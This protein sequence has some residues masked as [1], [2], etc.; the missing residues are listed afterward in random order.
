MVRTTYNPLVQWA[1]IHTQIRVARHLPAEEAAQCRHYVDRAFQYAERYPHDGRTLFLAAELRGRL[2]RLASGID[3]H[4]NAITNVADRLLDRQD[5]TTSGLSGFFTE[6]Q[7]T[8]AYRS[9]AFSADPALALLRLYELRHLL[10]N[11][12]I[13]ARAQE[14]IARYVEQY[15]LADAFSNPFAL[16]PYG[17]FFHPPQR[18]RQRF[19][20][21][22]AGRGVRTFMHPYN[23]QGIVHGTS[24][25]LLSHAHLL[26]RAAHQFQHS[27]W[28]A[29][30]ERLLQWCLGHNPENRS[31]FSGVGYRHPVGY[32]YRIPQLPEAPVTGFIG[33]PDDTPYLETSTAIEWNTLEYWSIPY[34]HAAQAACWI[35]A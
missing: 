13:A 34:I 10:L 24:S 16:T 2:E 35:Q 33:A 7:R 6:S 30:A 9:I 12:A 26:A 32:S 11:P 28:R 3:S 23:E 27:G 25:V 4:T 14:A 19:R 31:L 5:R 21:A 15:L 20:E 17:I 1:F 22:G 29:A 18:D 8:D